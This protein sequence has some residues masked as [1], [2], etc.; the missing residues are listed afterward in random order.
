VIHFV[1]NLVFLLLSFIFFKVNSIIVK[2]T[3]KFKPTLIYV[4]SNHQQTRKQNMQIKWI[5]L[6]NSH[7]LNLC[8]AEK[9]RKGGIHRQNCLILPA[10]THMP[11]DTYVKDNYWCIEQATTSQVL[12]CL[13]HQA[14]CKMESTCDGIWLFKDHTI[15]ILF[16]FVLPILVVLSK[17]N[18]KTTMNT[19]GLILPIV[20][21]IIFHAWN[22]G[23]I[24][25]LHMNL[26]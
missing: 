7:F 8:L 9:P 19:K 5:I 21:N 16:P 3:S 10:Y 15:N 18:T 13:S 24:C 12:V 25:I 23:C 26:L 4:I 2:I 20:L 14:T 17:K 22:D 6:E 11:E 1:N